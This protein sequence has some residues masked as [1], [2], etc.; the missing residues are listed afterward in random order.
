MKR[1]RNLLA[2]GLV[3][4][5]LILITVSFIACGCSL[6][7]ID[8]GDGDMR[9]FEISESFN[10]IYVDISDADLTFVST[11]EESVRVVCENEKKKL[12]HSAEVKDGRL[13]ISLNDERKWYD[14]LTFSFKTPRIFVYLPEV[15][16]ASLLIKSDTGD[17]V[18]P[19]NFKFDT[20]DVSLSTGDVDFRASANDFIKISASTGDVELSGVSAKSI[21]VSLS[22]GDVELEN[23]EA[24]GISIKTTT[25][26]IEAAGLRIDGAFS[27]KVSTGDTELSD[28]ICKSYT[29][30][31]S[32][33]EITLNRFVCEGLMSIERDTG[34][35]TLRDSDAG[36]ILIETDTGDVSLELRSEKVFI[37]NTD[38]GR[39]RVPESTSGGKCKVTTDTG[40]ISATYK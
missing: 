11:D 3:A 32:T 9:T 10:E 4:L 18:I 23:C 15:E 35:V 2:I 14:Y 39:I 21:D 6:E 17:I 26:D 36:E 27:T 1:K 12:S 24:E 40:D 20:V 25:G 31:G 19:E 38:T 33:G 16:Y 29:S 5:G 7:N 28:V 8:G 22:T 34:N 30:E 13:E 37:T